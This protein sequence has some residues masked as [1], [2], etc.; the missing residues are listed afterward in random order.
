[1]RA[2]S[3]V[4]LMAFAANAVVYTGC[5]G[6][7]E[8]APGSHAG[9]DDGGSTSADGA[10]GG[11]G[12]SGTQGGGSSGGGG[13]SGTTG[14]ANDRASGGR[15]GSTMKQLVDFNSVAAQTNTVGISASTP[16]A[17]DVTSLYFVMGYTLMRVPLDG[18]SPSVL[19]HLPDAQANLS[20]DIEPFVTSTDVFLHYTQASSSTNSEEIV[21]VPIQGGSPTVLITSNGRI[22]GFAVGGP[23]IYFVD[24]DGTKAI[25][26]SG[27]AVRVLTSQVASGTTGLAAIGSQVVATEGD[28]TI[29]AVPVA[30]GP[31]TTLA[32]Q[33]QNAGFP[34]AC[35]TDVCWWTGAAPNAM[36][37][38]GPGEIA[39]LD[40]NGHL[41]TIPGAPSYPWALAFDGSS[42]F[43]A[44]GADVSPGSIVRVPIS[45]TPAMMTNGGFVAV[46]DEC[47]Y[48]STIYAFPLPDGGSAMGIFSVS[49]SYVTCCDTSG[50]CVAT[51]GSCPAPADGGPG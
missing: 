29:V 7:S 11:D 46:D 16:F 33:Q 26:T 32:T 8:V 38:G 31:P 41:T 43:E 9:T 49:K 40:A 17:V 51:T 4:L 2:S 42:F 30:G 48:F 13:G 25:P 34:L 20:L 45:G 35:G 10:G 3:G 19:A 23:N 44:V 12:S 50:N 28:G 24:T 39:R 36:V 47:A 22:F 27:G 5:Q 37:S 18:G 1:M 15:C 6:S 14:T 21:G